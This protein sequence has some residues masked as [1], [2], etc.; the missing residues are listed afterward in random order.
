MPELV[1]FGETALRLSTP[2][3]ERL[4]AADV[5]ELYVDGEESNVAVAA[6]CLGT[7]CTWLS[8]LPETPM[9]R[10]IVADLRRHDVAVDVTWTDEG[11]VGVCYH[12]P[13]VDPRPSGLYH[14]REGTTAA[15][16]T[17]G[18]IPMDRVQAGDVVFSGTSTPAISEGAAETTEAMLRASAG[19]GATTA[20]DL[21]YAPGRHDPDFLGELLRRLFR[22]VDV[23]FA[24]EAHVRTVLDVSGKPRELA[25][26]LVA[27]YDLEMVVVT[28]SEYGAVVMH[29]APGTSVIHEQDALDG[30]VV[31][32]TGTRA[33][34]VGGFLAKL[35]EDADA[36]EALTYGVATAALARTV[37]G[38]TLST[39]PSE[40]DAVAEQVDDTAR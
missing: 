27:E 37:P 22:H 36:A 30:E 35:A 2:D 9:G 20:V 14:D 23:F 12:E 17:P 28:R 33:A 31:D 7:D 15:T 26:T 21:D 29:D 34:F 19:G 24:N 16:V 5:A 13:G 10:R 3:S 38:P 18:D 1:T 39:R 25:N 11:R 40:I 6:S 4:T 32:P 8:K